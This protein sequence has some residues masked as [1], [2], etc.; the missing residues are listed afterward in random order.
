MAAGTN[1]V[2]VQAG[3]L[4]AGDPAY[5]GSFQLLGRI[6]HRPVAT[7]YLG[8]DPLRRMAVV[9]LLREQ[10]RSETPR[11]EYERSLVAAQRITGRTVAPVLETGWDAGRP[12]LA[13]RYVPG[14]PAG[15]ILVAPELQ[16][17]ELLAFAAAIASGLDALH[18]AGVVHG[19]LGPHS[20]VLSERGP[21]VTG[22]GGPP[23]HHGRRRGPWV[24]PEPARNVRAATDVYAWG[25][26]VAAAALGAEQVKFK[27]LRRGSRLLSTDLSALPAPL[28]ALV[29]QALH[30]YPPARPTAERLAQALPL[31]QFPPRRVPPVVLAPH[32]YRP[33]TPGAGRRAAALATAVAILTIAVS[34]GALV[35]AL[36]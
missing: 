8:V 34:V 5:L 15:D 24:A 19:D 35:A 4:R 9:T 10:A 2:E 18:R 29:E 31:R 25:W 16:P 11:E 33:P 7:A 30:P 14:R 12:W 26:L 32:S 3:P 27:E 20:V 22:F 36:R 23:L 13:V 1:F 28:P 17:D 6:W 21:V